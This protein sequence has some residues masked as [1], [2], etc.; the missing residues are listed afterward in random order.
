MMRSLV[1]LFL[2][3]CFSVSFIACKKDKVLTDPSAKVSFS[4]D[5]ILFDTVFTTIGSAT[6][7]I[8]IRNGMKNKKREKLKF[9]VISHL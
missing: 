4:Q 6:Q 3:I 5:S 7:N 1:I 8:R 9:K 2:T